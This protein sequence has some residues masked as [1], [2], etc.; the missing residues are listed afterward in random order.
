MTTSLRERPPS[1]AVAKGGNA[2]ARR[3]VVRWA[4]RLF[5]REWRRQALVLALLVVAIAATT[6]GLGA[7]SNATVLKANPTFGTA[8]TIVSLPGSDAKLSADIAALRDRFGTV[9]VIAHE[10]VPIPGSVT[11]LDVRAEDPNGP[12]GHV[13]LRLDSGRYPQGAGEVAMTAG[14]AKTFGVHIGDQWPADGRALRVV[15]MVENPL[16]LLDEFALVAPGQLNRTA[17]VSILL[18][19]GHQAFD[20][21]RLPSHTGL[22][23]S[24]RGTTNQAAVTAAVLVLAT[25]GLLF[26][27][28]MSVAGF[29][30]MARRR[31][32]ALGMLASLGAT[33]R[34]LRLVVLAN[35]AIVGATAAIVGTVVGLAGWFAVAPALESVTKHRINR[36]DLPWWALGTAML[37]TFATAVT[38]A[39]WPARAVGRLSPMAALSGRPPRPQPPHRFA[40]AGLLLLAGGVVLLAFADGKR[41]G[42]ILGGTA[43]TAIGLLLLAPLA[44]RLLASAGRRSPI[45]VTLALRDLAR[46]QARSGAALG[47]ITLAIGIAATICINASATEKPTGPGNLAA[48]QLMLYVS[49]ASLGDPWPS[50]SAAQLQTAKTNVDDLAATLH[51]SALPLDQTYDAGAPALPLSQANNGPTSISPG[52]TAPTGGQPSGYL[53]PMLAT[54]TATGRGERV[55]DSIVLYVATPAVL[56]QYGITA[57]EID[58]NADVITAR[59]DLGGRQI[60]DPT[61]KGRAGASFGRGKD[62]TKPTIQVMSQL[63]RFTSAP[64]V[65]LTPHGMQTL[66]LKPLPAAWMLQTRT[67]LTAAQIDLATKAAAGAG[68]YVEAR[69]PPQSLAALRNWSTAAGILLALGVLGMTVGLIRSETAGDLRTLAAT[70]ASSN[71]RRALTAVT[72]GALALLGG[73]IGTGGAYA[74]LLAWYRSNLTPLG[75]VPV[76]NLVLLVVGLPVIATVTGWLLAGREQV[77]MARQPLE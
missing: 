23:V 69:K 26:V 7:T 48:N 50:L 33:D 27:G 58:P 77:G 13:M 34:H 47:A 16:N 5:R 10:T 68:L 74:A 20:S 22:A 73:L 37:L 17:S 72:A 2:P 54:V 62:A 46:Y 49:R 67:P 65:L 25:L 8:Q 19:A 12:Y 66:G 43:T 63:P 24:G 71:T 45:A 52:E 38:A 35:G 59:T 44:I 70:G 42:F 76:I 18:N 30:V 9:E 61:P 11:N 1:G 60:F 75:Q 3:A 57:A 55:S 41:V 21:L 31:Q 32:R 40:A 36:L 53:T 15:G 4:W 14:A 51:A 28:L 64:G 39:W 6:I 56:A 29:A